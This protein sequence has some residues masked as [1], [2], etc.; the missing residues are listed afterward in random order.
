MQ[1]K[2]IKKREEETEKFMKSINTQGTSQLGRDE[3][4]NMWDS[5]YEKVET[6]MM[7]F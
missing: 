3:Y 6:T 7:M 4:D 5:V 1:E 2:I